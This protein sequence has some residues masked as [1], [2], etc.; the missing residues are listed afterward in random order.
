[1]EP[2]TS[3]PDAVAA[4]VRAAI[5]AHETTVNA[6]AL[7]IGMTRNT[8]LRRLNGSFTVTELDRIATHLGVPVEQFTAP[9]RAA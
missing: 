5:D 3:Y 7:G 2:N 9:R 8:F 6:V 4:A 1:M